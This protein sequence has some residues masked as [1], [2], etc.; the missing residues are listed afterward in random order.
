MQSTQE[1]IARNIKPGSEYFLLKYV[2]AHWPFS[3]L[4]LFFH[5]L[6]ESL[7]F[8]NTIT[9]F[10]VSGLLFLS[11]DPSAQFHLEYAYSFTR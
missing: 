1:A 11:G 3:L 5:S 2:V 10:H 8:I 4:D 6:A 7:R 9:C